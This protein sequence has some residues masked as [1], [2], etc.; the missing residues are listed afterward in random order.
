MREIQEGSGPGQ[1][2]AP[3]PARTQTPTRER[4]PPRQHPF[5]SLR[6]GRCRIVVSLPAMQ[7]CRMRGEIGRREIEVSRPPSLPPSLPPSPP[8]PLSRL[9]EGILQLRELLRLLPAHLQPRLQLP[10]HLTPPHPPTPPPPPRALVLR[11][12][13]LGPD[14]SPP[15]LQYAAAAPALRCQ[16]CTP[17][18]H[19]RA[20]AAPRP[21]H[22]R[23]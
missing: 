6:R 5:V 1:P 12:C 4:G 8:P 7:R 19:G 9:L 3:P 14:P 23:R 15:R 2:G 10:L 22:Q 20:P 11:V 18:A 13:G 16:A 21:I 17:P